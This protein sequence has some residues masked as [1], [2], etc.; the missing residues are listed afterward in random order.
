MV[1][2]R[3]KVSKQNDE[4]YATILSR[5]I[6]NEI[7]PYLNIPM[8]EEISDSEREELNSLEL[9]IFTNRED[10]AV[11]SEESEDEPVEEPVGEIY[12]IDIDPFKDGD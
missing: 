2:D 9:T 7:L 10:D 6:L 5:E 3:P 4:S 1:T 12:G 11:L 8:T